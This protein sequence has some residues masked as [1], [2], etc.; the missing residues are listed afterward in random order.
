MQKVN[1]HS[2]TYRCGHADFNMSDED[3]VKEYIE[4]GFKEIAFTDHAPEKNKI[5]KRTDM[6]MEYDERKDYLNSINKLKEKYKD[7]INIKSGYEIEYLPGEEENMI[8]LKNEVDLLILG[9]HFIYDNDNNLKIFGRHKITDEELLRYANYID[10]ALKLNIPS[11]LVHPDIFMLSSNE[12]GET[13]KEITKMICESAQKYNIPLEINLNNIYS[14]TYLRGIDYFNI[15][16]D[17]KKEILNKIS[18]PN[19]EFWNIV[20]NYDIK[21]LYGIDAHYKGQIL[22][23]NDLVKIANEI[24]GKD[25]INKLNFIDKL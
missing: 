10:N 25:T 17:S 18:Y 4:M 21:V 11:I 5:D 8:E 6:R 16:N 20:S 23:F 19:K 2:H 22:L 15:S 13:E 7:V 9:Q 1:Y 3:Y 12:F 14:R 24:I